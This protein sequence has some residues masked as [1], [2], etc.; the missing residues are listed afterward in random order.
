MKYRTALLSLWALAPTAALA[1]PLN[2]APLVVGDSTPL[3]VNYGAPRAM[4]PAVLPPG[5]WQWQLSVDMGNT[6]HI[7]QDS[8]Y[9]EQLVLDGETSRYNLALEYGLSEDWDMRLDIPYVG[10]KGGSL[11][12]F[13]DDFHA[14]LG[15]PEGSRPGRAEDRFQ[16]LYQ[17]NGNT[18]L[19]ASSASGLGDPS[20]SV[21]RTVDSEYEDSLSYGFSLK[22]PSD[23]D[24]ST[25]TRD[26]AV[27]A[28]AADWLAPNWLHYVSAGGVWVERDKGWLAELRKSGYGFLR[29]GV[30]WRVHPA[31]TLKLQAD[32]QSAL[33]KQTNSRLLGHSSALAMGGTLQ[34]AEHWQLDI[35]VVE[36]IDVATTSDVVFHFNLRKRYGR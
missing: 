9:G 5:Q 10:Y 25:Q 36:D 29:Y 34:L 22:L 13:I 1:A 26:I 28:S 33:F 15:F 23:S 7:E 4:A 17:R 18:L 16:L 8:R 11:D 21:V 20:L 3:M 24:V 30:Q 14:A 2:F 27:W 31:V 6:L 19:D 12:G 35:A 32:A